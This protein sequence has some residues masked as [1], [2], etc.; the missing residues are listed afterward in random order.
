MRNKGFVMCA[1]VATLVAGFGAAISEAASS[2]GRADLSPSASMPEAKGK[3]SVSVKQWSK[4][5]F[6]LSARGLSSSASYELLVGGI[7]VGEIHT[8]KGGSGKARFANPQGRNDDLLGFDPRGESIEVRDASGNDVLTGNMSTDDVATEVTCCIPHEGG[9]AECEDRSAADCATANGTVVAAGS[10]LPDPCGATPPVGVSTV[11]CVP[12]D[13]GPECDDISQSAC[14]MRG[15]VM[16]EATSCALPNPCAGTPPPADDHV[17]CCVA[18]SSGIECEDRTVALCAAAGGI[19]KGPGTCTPNPCSDVSPPADNMCCVP[20]AAGTEIECEDIA[21][22]SCAIAGGTSQGA[23]VCAIDTCNS[24]PPPDPQVMCCLPNLAGTEIECQDRS[25]TECATQG[26]VNK[27]AGVCS[28]TICAD[29]PTPGGVTGQCCERHNGGYE[30]RDRTAERCATE[31]GT[32]KGDGACTLTS[33]D[34]L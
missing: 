30:C 31:G 25:A 7:K 10:C 13:S 24:V 17:Q 15:G 14:A 5:K 19:N 1:L 34:G 6:K 22:A 3:A 29:V 2:K 4:G 21:A 16:I 9:G 27:G 12:D 23:G 18:G 32:Y 11:C 8:N 20:N 28:L 33:C 26:G